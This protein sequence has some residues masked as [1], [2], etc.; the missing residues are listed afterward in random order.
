MSDTQTV[1]AICCGLA[2]N[3]LEL[4]D[5]CAS[6]LLSGDGYWPSTT[7][8]SIFVL[9]FFTYFDNIRQFKL[10]LNYVYIVHLVLG[11]IWCSHK[12]ACRSHLLVVKTR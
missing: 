9:L 5:V 6:K 8:V 10:Q 12:K 7:W 3:W 11:D 4:G 1:V 2:N